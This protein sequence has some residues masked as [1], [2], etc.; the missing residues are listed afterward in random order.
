M[1][2]VA[3][4]MLSV[5]VILY[6]D[7]ELIAVCLAWAVVEARRTGWLA[8]E[9]SFFLVAFILA[10][11]AGLMRDL[12]HASALPA[13][14]LGLMALAW[15]RAA[16]SCSDGESSRQ[17][18]SFRQLIGRRANTTTSTIRQMLETDFIRNSTRN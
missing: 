14:T 12:V 2:L 4:T 5:P 15:R 3:G 13:L 10:L 6:Y 17:S 11:G 8:W 16:L 18:G 9:K 7:S 1:A